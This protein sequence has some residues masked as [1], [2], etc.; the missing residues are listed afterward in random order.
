MAV[1]RLAR[2]ELGV[3]MDNISQVFRDF[4]SSIVPGS[5]GDSVAELLFS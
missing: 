4:G 5:D 1:K 2:E 3:D